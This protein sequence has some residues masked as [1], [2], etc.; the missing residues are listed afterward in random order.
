M[1][2]GYVPMTALRSTLPK[3]SER[4]LVLAAEQQRLEEEEARQDTPKGAHLAEKIRQR[5]LTACRFPSKHGRTRVL[6]AFASVCRSKHAG[7]SS[8]HAVPVTT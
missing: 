2:D 4:E 8:Y 6:V 5:W 7:C 3:E 1:V